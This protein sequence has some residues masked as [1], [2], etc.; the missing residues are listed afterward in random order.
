MLKKAASRGVITDPKKLDA[1]VRA[2]GK[3]L[4]IDDGGIPPHEWLWAMRN[5][6]D[7]EIV[8]LRTPGGGVFGAGGEYLGEEL[9][10][11]GEALFQAM[12]SS[13]LDQFA[14]A[15]IELV[16]NDR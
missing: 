9:T 15:N 13:K 7:N 5:I 1:V 10:A 2:A 14:A 8:M 16:N 6:G 4:T 3:A 11:Q 12:R